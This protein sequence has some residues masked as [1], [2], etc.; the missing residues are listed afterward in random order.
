MKRWGELSI[1]IAVRV[2]LLA[3]VL[4]AAAN[5]RCV[6]DEPY[7][8]WIRDA[9]RYGTTLEKRERKRAARD[10]L[11]ARGGEALRE[12]MRRVHIKNVMLGVLAQE[13]V[14]K[15]PPDEAAAVLV[16][17]LDSPNAD[18]RRMA[19]FFLSLRVTPQYADRVLPLLDDPEAA[20]AALRALGKWRV[21]SAAPRIAEFLSHEREVRRIVAVNALRDLGDPSAIPLLQPLL[22]DRVFTVR[23]AAARAIRALESAAP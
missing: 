10:E 21:R 13:M 22:R 1:C 23:R 14:E 4:G 12:V 8:E 18:T 2:F 16:E 17:F 19:A 6:A 3:V 7:E 5:P 20:G 15:L 11:F 9:V